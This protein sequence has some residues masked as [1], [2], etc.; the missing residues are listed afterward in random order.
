MKHPFRISGNLKSLSKTPFDKNKG[1]VF[2]VHGY[3]IPF[4]GIG[5]KI[6]IE[7]TPP[8]IPLALLYTYTIVTR[9]FRGSLPKTLRLQRPGRGMAGSF[10]AVLLG[11]HFCSS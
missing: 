1:T 4:D 5:T 8:K 2:V 7:G 10:M 11:R 3:K 9:F 6:T